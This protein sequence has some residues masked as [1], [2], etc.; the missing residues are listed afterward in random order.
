MLIPNSS[1]FLTEAE[2]FDRI[3]GLLLGCA[4]GD[5]VGLPAEGMSRARIARRW[6]GEWRQRLLFGWGMLS[7]DTEHTLMTAVALASSAGEKDRF[8]GELARQMRWWFAGLPAGVGLA[9]GRSMLKSWLGFPPDRSGVFSAGNGP[10]MRSAIIGAMFHEDRDRMWTHVRASS[11]ITHTDPRAI[12]GAGSIAALAAWCMRHRVNARPEPSELGALLRGCGG[13]AEWLTIC[14]TIE[15]ACERGS[16]VEEFVDRLGLRHGVTGY[17][18]HSVPVAIFCWWK[19]PGDTTAGLGA[20]FDCGGDT[21]TV[22]AIAGS[23]FGVSGGVTGLP[24]DWINKLCDW[25]R[26][27]NYI[28]NVADSIFGASQPKASPSFW[29][30]SLVRNVAFLGIVL[31]HGMRRLLPPY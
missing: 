30:C 17:I 29:V 2:R 6:N 23:L 27:L 16:S 7:D 26:S 25:P 19:H 10:A 14:K 21:D 15:D 1:D 9:T 3:Y 12:A 8:A 24:P 5:S 20:V 4:V 31:S 28:R 13:D 18:Y 11:L 22:G